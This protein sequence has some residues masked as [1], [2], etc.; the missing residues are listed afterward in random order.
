MRVCLLYKVSGCVASKN[1]PTQFGILTVK[2]RINY[3]KAQM[4]ATKLVQTVQHLSYED[5]L[6]KIGDSNITTQENERRSR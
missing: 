2:G 1:T 4:R 3:R 6:K 5:R